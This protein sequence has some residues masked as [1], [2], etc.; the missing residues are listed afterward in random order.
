MQLEALGAEV[1]VLQADVAIQAELKAAVAQAHQRFG[2]IH[3]VIHSAG[4]VGS[5]LISA[6]TEE[7]V[8]RRYLRQRYRERVH[9]KRYSRMNRWISC[10]CAHRW[11]PL[12][13]VSARSIIAQPMP[14]LMPLLALLI[15]NC[16]IPRDLGQLG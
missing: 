8:A 9:C 2:A 12:P 15:V 10:C 7:M 4:E 11:R 3:G 6:K 16:R 1:L 13:E 5:G 14:I